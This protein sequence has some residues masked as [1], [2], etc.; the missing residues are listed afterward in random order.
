MRRAGRGE[1]ATGV[2]AGPRLVIYVATP[3]RL[4][5]C[6]TFRLRLPS[7]RTA[8]LFRA[9]AAVVEEGT[10]RVTGD[11]MGIV[12]L[13]PAHVS[14]VD[15]E[16]RSE[17][18]EE[19]VADGEA[20]MTVN[21]QELLKFLKRARKGEAL[22]LTYDEEKRKLSI[23]LTDPT[24]SRERR[25]ELATLEWR[26]EPPKI[27]NLTFTAKAT[28]LTDAL[29][30]AVEDA[31]L[32]SDSVKITIRP[33]MVVFLAE[34]WGDGGAVENRLSNSSPLVYEIE[35]DG[36]VAASYSLSYLE[37]IVGA[38]R[39]SDIVTIELSTNKPLRLTF[40][41]AEGRLQYLLA[42]RAE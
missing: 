29:W 24:K 27:P 11:S 5:W 19:F 28:V 4:G 6:D 18:A 20:E 15:F 40:N 9:V 34:G 2:W 42:P 13:D 17:A 14:L 39:F 3:I 36:D 7:A 23:I 8:D 33:D 21:L 26:A 10:F 38:A 25:F 31:R 16:L 1:G 32:V 12:S 41:L 37:K 30:E 22:T 35:A